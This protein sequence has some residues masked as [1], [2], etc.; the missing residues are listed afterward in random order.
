MSRKIE[1]LKPDVQPPVRIL[2]AHIAE[3]GIKF[4][5][6]DTDRTVWNQVA[7]WLQHR[8]SLEAVNLVRTAQGMRPISADENT[9]FVTWMDGVNSLSA[10]QGGRAIDIVP[11][12]PR[13]GA[14]TW[15]YLTFR[16][17]YKAI[18][19]V[20]RELGFECGQD[21]PP[22]DPVTGMG[23]DPPHYQYPMRPV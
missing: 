12:D 15:D 8:V 11:L 4:S 17:A 23:K 5:T 1:D 18:A 19:T 22:F 16:A 10:H 9:Y 21:W 2:L 7:L 14:P 3:L 20:A 13:T 6:G